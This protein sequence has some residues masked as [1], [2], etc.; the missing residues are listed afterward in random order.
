MKNEHVYIVGETVKSKM[1]WNTG[2]S[3]KVIDTQDPIFMNGVRIVNQFV[4]LQY[5]DD[6]EDVSGWLSAHEIEP[7]E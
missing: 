4:K 7:I 2:A 3:C 6:L 5:S 1:R